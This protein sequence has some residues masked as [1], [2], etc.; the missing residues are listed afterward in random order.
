MRLLDKGKWW[1]K[2]ILQSEVSKIN[3]RKTSKIYWMSFCEDKATVLCFQ[4]MIP[5]RSRQQASGF[6][7][8]NQLQ[9]EIPS[10]LKGHLN[11]FITLK[12]NKIWVFC[13]LQ[14]KTMSKHSYTSEVMISMAPSGRTLVI[15][16]IQE[17][18]VPCSIRH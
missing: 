1:T 12:F 16:L 6:N 10:A 2:V 18:Q 8:C 13:Y 9:L 5:S 15:V 17:P 14:G 4:G 7:Q 3:Q 11:G